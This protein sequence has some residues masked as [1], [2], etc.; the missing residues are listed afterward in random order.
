MLYGSET[1]VMNP[2]IGSVFGISHHRMDHRMTGRQPWQVRYELW[3]YPPLEAAMAEVVLKE[4]NTY[5]Y[6]HQN[7]V[8]NFITNRPIMY[9]CLAT[10]RRLG[11]RVTKH[12]WE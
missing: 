1:W 2:H 4:V 12:Y 3:L 10:E 8:A 7:T 5:V 9:L 11:S 6:R